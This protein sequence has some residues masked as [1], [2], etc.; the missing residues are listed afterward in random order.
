MN[1]KFT[2]LNLITILTLFFSACGGQSR[3]NLPQDQGESTLEETDTPPTEPP[4]PTPTPTFTFTPTFTPTS[5]PFSG[6]GSELGP[7][8]EDFP[9]GI[10]PL[11]GLP[12]TDPTLLD[13]PAI[14]ISIP[15]F[16][17]SGRPS[18]GISYA[19]WI[20]EIYIGEGTTRLLATF[21]G[22]EPGVEPRPSGTCEVPTEPFVATGEVLGNRAWIDNNAN[23]VQDPDELGVGGICVTLYDSAGNILQTTSTD[24]NGYYGFNVEA[25]QTYLVGFE[26]PGGLDFTTPD[27]GFDDLDSDTD[28]LTGLTPPILLTATDM[29]WDAGYVP[30]VEPVKP[31]PTVGEGTP[32]PTP[33]TTLG[34]GGGDAALPPAEVGPI[35]SMRLAYGKIAKFFQG[36][37]IV[38]CSG[39]PAVLAQVP[40]CEYVFGD[41]SNAN[42]ALFNITDMTD[43]AEGN[44]KDYQINYSGN[45]FDS[46][47]PDGGKPASEVDVFWNVQNQS[48]FRYDPLSGAYQRF[49]NRP[50]EESIFTP[51]TDRL[52]GRQLLYENIIVMYVKHMA[53]AETLIDID[54][55]I[56]ETGDTGL[57][58]NGQFYPIYWNTIAQD[59][60]QQTEHLRPIRFTDADGNP[61]PL[62][63]GHTWVNV[64]TT[65]SVV[66]EKLVGSGI[67]TAEFHAPIVGK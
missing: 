1:K 51:Q 21:Y 13:L 44:K 12:V 56:G 61:F 28:P 52:T 64:F 66:Y 32:S 58:R 47:P 11:T 4:V 29:N 40:G 33:D 15:L 55:T 34:G 43:L 7:Q 60:E 54:L 49:A 57:F 10:N 48:L 2:L 53:R 62:A 65:A 31:T 14:M 67:W 27:V 37:C 30:T 36:G 39:D 59:Y 6:N 23:G 20:F 38:S 24:S 18:A 46:V 9:P 63:P 35:R 5:Q 16:P 19:P 26:D 41:G 3:E 45:L 8:I 25:S 22:E 50:G 42:D 17:A